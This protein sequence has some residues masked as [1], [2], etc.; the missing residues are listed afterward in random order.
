MTSITEADVEQAA[1]DWLFALGW[2]VAHG[3]EIAPDTPN[4]ERGDYGQAVLERRVQ[5]SLAELNPSL[6]PPALDD[7]F[8]KLTL[9]EGATLEARN[10]AFHRMVVDGVTVEH[11]DSEGRIRGAQVKVV[12]FDD[13]RQQRLAGGQPV[14][15][16]RE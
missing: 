13:P 4:A 11:R 12:D 1:L 2:Q 6:P 8:R 3:P 16:H 15:S 9:S 7:A 10:R 14:H 5:D